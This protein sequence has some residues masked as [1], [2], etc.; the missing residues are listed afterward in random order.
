MVEAARQCASH[1]HDVNYQDELRRTAEDLRD[2]TV[3]AATTSAL[4]AKLVNRVQVCA[5]KAISSAT[6]AITA[7]QASHP[8]NT[9][10]STRQSLSQ[11]T[12]ELAETIPPL[13]E[14]IKAS[15]QNPEDSN[16][17]VELMYIA[18]VFLHPATQFVNTAR[19]VFLET[20]HNV[21]ILQL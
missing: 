16:S 5:K 15:G 11:D 12:M 4:R 14:S 18:E 20:L 7:A 6:Q 17:Q 9:N 21:F 1:P 8:H 13:V 10:A 2:V 19:W 3:V